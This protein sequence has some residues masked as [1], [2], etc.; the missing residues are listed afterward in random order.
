MAKRANYIVNAPLGRL[1]VRESPSLDARILSTLETGAKVTA[2]GI[3]ASE[4]VGSHSRSF[5]T[6]GDVAQEITAEEA[7]LASIARRY[8]LPTGLLYRG[9]TG[10]VH[11]AHCNGL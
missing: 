7:K 4:S 1:N 11:T 8:L 9:V 2:D 10:C 5:K 6:G 3:I